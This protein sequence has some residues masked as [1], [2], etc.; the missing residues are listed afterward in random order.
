M[1]LIMTETGFSTTGF[2]TALAIVVGAIVLIAAVVYMQLAERRIPV[3]YSKKVVGRK[4]GVNCTF[5]HGTTVIEDDIKII[6][7]DNFRLI[8]YLD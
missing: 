8:K 2:L 3:Q 4:R 6:W 7:S 5:Y 1:N